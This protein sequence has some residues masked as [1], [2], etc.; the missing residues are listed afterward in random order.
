MGEP[1]L[2]TPFGTL[3]LVEMYLHYD[4]PRLFSAISP[5]D[6][7][8][9][10]TWFGQTDPGTDDWLLAPVSATRLEAIR[11]GH[12]DIHD[13][14]RLVETGSLYLLRSPLGDAPIRSVAAKEIPEED[15]ADP[16]EIL[17]ETGTLRAVLEELARRQVRPLQEAAE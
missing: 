1:I 15:L 10:I 8:F 14:F 7:L 4:G 3:F 16:G 2:D 13:A 6:N 5:T 11:S 9:L 12:I 17:E